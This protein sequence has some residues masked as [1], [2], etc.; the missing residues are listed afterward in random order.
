MPRSTV[1]HLR[2]IG[3]DA[4]HVG[5]LGL[6]AE[7]DEAVLNEGRLR[8]AVVVTLDAVFHAILARIRASLPSVVCIRT[9]GLKGEGVARLLGQV[10]RAVESDLLAGAAV[11]V[12]DRRLALRRLPLLAEELTEPTQNGTDN[13]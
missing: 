11:T 2:A 10:V 1:Q 8:D 3:L 4:E 12:T 7:T 5:Q 6:A 9:Q 13:S